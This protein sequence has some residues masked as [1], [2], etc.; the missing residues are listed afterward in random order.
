MESLK[1]LGL[2]II[3]LILLAFFDLGLALLLKYGWNNHISVAFSWVK[4]TY[5]QAFW[6]FFFIHGMFKSPHLK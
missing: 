5:W 2:A 6:I 1:K 3:Y 4:I